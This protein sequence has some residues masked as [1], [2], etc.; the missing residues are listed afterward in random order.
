MTANLLTPKQVARAIGVSESSLKR[1]CDRGT[2]A[3]VKTAGG[4]RRI[5]VADVLAFLRDSG[6]RVVN[7]EVLGLPA[8]LG[9]GERTWE[10]S[11]ERYLTALVTGDEAVA[12]Q[13]VFDLYLAGRPISELADS[14]FHPVLLE[15]GQRWQCGEAEVYQERRACE[16]TNRVLSELRTLLPEPA[17]NAP[18]AIGA[19]PAGDQYRLPTLLV[20][21]V[22]R[23]LG[24]QAMSLGSN[25]PFETL[26]AAIA[27]HRPRLFWLS[28]SHLDDAAT[29]VREYEAF[30]EVLN[31]RPAIVLGGNALDES[32]RKQLTYATYCDNLRQ[33]IAYVDSL[34]LGAAQLRR[35]KLVIRDGEVA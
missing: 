35:P 10:R 7:P 17:A 19:T 34:G 24:W 1:W 22:L 27:R 18:I 8:A 12:R 32:L 16:I 14:L 13:V 9:S 5:Q 33:L 23:E 2:I 20:E 21:L 4:H 28:V 29:F 30:Y 26:A 25:L 11:R 3:T 15:I 31:P 6:H